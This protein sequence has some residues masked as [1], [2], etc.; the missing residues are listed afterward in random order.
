MEERSRGRAYEKL[1][2]SV[3]SITFKSE[4]TGFTVLELNTG[5]ELVTV[6]GSM[7]DVEVGEELSLS[8]IH[9]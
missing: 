9:I 8:L 6:V 3:D 7:V 1:E 4:D 2:G 5:E